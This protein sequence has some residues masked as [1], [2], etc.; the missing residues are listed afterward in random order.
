MQALIISDTRRGMKVRHK[1][2]VRLKIE[3]DA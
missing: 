2:G 3:P 1:K